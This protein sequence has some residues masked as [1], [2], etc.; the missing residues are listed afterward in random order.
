MK[1]NNFIII[2]YFLGLSSCNSA[3]SV[4]ENTNFKF[5]QREKIIGENLKPEANHLKVDAAKDDLVVKI[6]EIAKLVKARIILDREKIEPLDQFGMKDFVFS[7]L[8]LDSN[9]EKYSHNENKDIRR[10]FY[11]SLNC[12]EKLII[13]FGE[14]L[15]KISSD[16]DKS[17]IRFAYF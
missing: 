7:N 13:V 5:N 8:I 2:I 16:T 12:D 4:L 1:K 10:K 11:S 9:R 3:N 17:K 6:I 15:N 14:I